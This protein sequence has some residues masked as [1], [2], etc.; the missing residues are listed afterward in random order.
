[1]RQ[2]RL[3]Y[4]LLL[5]LLPGVLF[6]Q[7][8]KIRGT[9]V[10]QK[11]KEP[12][13]GANI[14]IE[15]TSLGAATDIDGAFMILNVPIG[16][17][18]VKA[19]YVGYRTFTIS[20]IRVSGLLT[21]EVNFELSSE[22][23]QVQTVEI[24]AERPLVNKNATNAVRSATAEDIQN[25]P[26]RGVGNIVALVPGVV[27]QQGV[28]YIRGGRREQVGYIV[29]GVQTRDALLGGSSVTINDNAIEEVQVQ[30]GGYNAEYGAAN[31]GIVI[32]S[33]KTG[34]EKIK[35]TAEI[36]T[37]GWG[38][39]GS[40]KTLGA[41]SYGYSEYTATIGGAIPELNS[42]K[43]FL[44]GTNQFNRTVIKRW[45]GINLHG[46]SD[47]TAANQAPIDLVAPAGKMLNNAEMRWTLNGNIMTSV[48]PF[49]K[50]FDIKLSGW[51]T[52]L[53]QHGNNGST[54]NFRGADLDQILNSSRLPLTETKE[55]GTVLHITH[56]LTPSTIIEVNLSYSQND[57]ETMDPYLKDKWWLYGDSI[58][59]AQYGFTLKGDGEDPVHTILFGTQINGRGT[60]E[61]DYGKNKRRSYSVKADLTHQ[62]GKLHEFK[63]GAE[64]TQYIMRN[65]GLTSDFCVSYAASVKSGRT[66]YEI[67]SGVRLNS[68]GYDFMGQNE[69]DDIKGHL[70]YQ[71][72]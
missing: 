19:S 9:V 43:F 33:L 57:F 39:P 48:K 46:L 65:W 5:L 62:V 54:A 17:F 44:S 24:V 27:Q 21:T 26:V 37:D 70:G 67:L 23:V 34:G 1:M 18:T 7:S 50:K 69:V 51:Y 56:E 11:T 36:I 59:N 41:N 71:A 8:G 3:Y 61:S 2:K 10:D 53:T 40:G 31:A 28:I 45:E 13:I 66:P 47:V 25:I 58:A 22:D 72:T 63:A 38:T 6:A 14:I 42:V 35:A 64:Y 32:T 60:I 20:N 4:L 29:E 16:T 12:L 52:S 30:A 49:D 15:G 55:M 68:Y